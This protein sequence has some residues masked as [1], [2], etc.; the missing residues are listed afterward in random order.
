MNSK[1]IFSI[2]ISIFF[3]VVIG[4]IT[5][6]ILFEKYGSGKNVDVNIYYLN[7]IS[8]KLEPEKRTI[9]N[10]DELQLLERI[11]QEMISMPKNTTLVGVFADN[12][13]IIDCKLITDDTGTA[14]VNFSK[15][16]YNLKES[17]ELF[18]RASVVWTLTELDF[19]DN[20]HIYIDGKPLLRANGEIVGDLNRDNVIVDPVI[21]PEKTNTQN[22]T[23]Y[24]SDDQSM[25]LKAEVR[26][27]EV[28]QS[29]TLENQIVEQL[30]IGP[31]ESGNYPTIPIETKI[32]DIKTDSGTC[33]VDLSNEFVSK[34]NGGTSAEMMTIYSIVNSLTELENV[35]NVQFLIEGKKVDY[36]KG[37]FDFSKT[38][39]RNEDLIS[40]DKG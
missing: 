18:C 13:K 34:H 33:Y 19:I 7:P 6:T 2:G 22:V 31:E 30:I 5:A 28:K 24:F 4:V 27:I 9:K 26:T 15:E 36:F 10:G 37:H 12:V 39:E 20:V 8:N 32:R 11:L 35:K 29:Q 17:Q 16:Y 21:S 3:I 1:R 38:F 25:F 23:L 40:K 14:E